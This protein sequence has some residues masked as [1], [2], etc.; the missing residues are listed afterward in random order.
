MK[1]ISLLIAN[2]VGSAILTDFMGYFRD[3]DV[4]K[5]MVG[6]LIV[7]VISYLAWSH[8]ERER[9]RW[10]Y[11]F[12]GAVLLIMDTLLL[13]ED[14]GMM[15]FTATVVVLALLNAFVYWVVDGIMISPSDDDNSPEQPQKPL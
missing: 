15:S 7:A 5:L 9:C 14:A 8:S 1:T 4:T 11:V 13:K 12:T 2:F 10:Y 3:C 6:L